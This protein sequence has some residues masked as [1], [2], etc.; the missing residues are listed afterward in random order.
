MLREDNVAAAYGAHEDAEEAVKALHRAGYD[1]T[2]L[3]IVYD[4]C[5]IEERILGFHD[6]SQRVGYWGKVGAISGSILGMMIGVALL[7]GPAITLAL[8]VDLL[9]AGL[10]AG[11]L[12]G[13]FSAAGAFV[14][15]KLLIGNAALKYELGSEG[16]DRFSLVTN[17]ADDAVEAQALMRRLDE[18]STPGRSGRANESQALGSA[19]GIR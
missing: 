2:K 8:T 13:G 5:R 15:G 7:S 1:I 10:A 14:Y 6:E 11:L 4:G 18:S 12:G 19:A 16:E 3:S 9:A 17:K